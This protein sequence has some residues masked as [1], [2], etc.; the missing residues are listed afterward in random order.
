MILL[1][2]LLL[3]VYLLLPIE[4]RTG[5]RSTLSPEPGATSPAVEEKPVAESPAA[6]SGIELETICGARTKKGTPCR[7]KTRQGSRCYQHTG[8]PSLLD[9]PHRSPD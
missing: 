4:P 2:A 6:T 9:S 1:G 5:S 7:R 8:M 3:A